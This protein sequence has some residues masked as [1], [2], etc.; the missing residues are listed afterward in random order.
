MVSQIN[1]PKFKICQG[2]HCTISIRDE[3]PISFLKIALILEKDTITLIK[4]VP[5]QVV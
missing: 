1:I 3:L 2:I 5:N 4:T